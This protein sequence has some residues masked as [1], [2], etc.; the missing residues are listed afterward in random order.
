MNIQPIR[1]YST[2][3][4]PTMA[5]VRREPQL[6]RRI[7]RRWQAP[8]RW[9]AAVGFGLLAESVLSAEPGPAPVDKDV[10]V[11]RPVPGAGATE[12]KK[13]DAQP[14]RPVTLVAPFQ[15]FGQER[16]GRGTFGCVAV[17]PPS[18][19]AEDEAMEIIRKE[20]EAA[21]LKLKEFGELHGIEMP[22]E[23]EFRGQRDEENPRFS[24]ADFSF[25]FADT[26]KSV[27]IEYLSKRDHQRWA[28]TSFSTV[29]AYDFPEVAQTF[30]T[31]L[32]KFK[33][34]KRTV[35]AIFFDPLPSP[36]REWVETTGLTKEQANLAQEESRKA[37]QAARDNLQAQGHEKL[38]AQVRNFIEFLRKQGIVKKTGA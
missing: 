37:D 19:L 16:D 5:E 14:T 7:P 31:S 3:Q 27:F 11:V 20:L 38:R 23:E 35:F 21:G 6:L 25:D 10:P 34:D 24:P 30:S 4:Y 33:A 2:A 26:E 17:N 22:V 12:E 18:F 32:Q 15:G 28:G 36:D 13:A 8:G 9:A 29:Q 1:H